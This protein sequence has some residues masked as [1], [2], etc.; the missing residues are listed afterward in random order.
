[1]ERSAHH[2]TLLE[3]ATGYRLAPGERIERTLRLMRQHSFATRGFAD[4]DDLQTRPI[5]WCA[6]AAAE[7]PRLPMP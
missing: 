2:L 5:P 1:M 4:L 7:C 6:G 3:L